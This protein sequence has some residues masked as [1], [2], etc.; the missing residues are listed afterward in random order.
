MKLL[1]L[2]EIKKAWKVCMTT[3]AKNHIIFQNSNRHKF[4]YTN[5]IIVFANSTPRSCL[6]QRYATT[7]HL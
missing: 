3:V 7:Y 2:E 1:V 5:N 6:L 4:I